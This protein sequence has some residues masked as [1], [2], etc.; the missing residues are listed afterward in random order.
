[1]P[2]KTKISKAGAKAAKLAIDN[3]TNVAEAVAE[4]VK[5]VCAPCAPTEAAIDAA[6][7]T[8]ANTD[9]TDDAVHDAVTVL[10][11]KRAAG[12]AK[13]VNVHVASTDSDRDDAFLAALAGTVN[14]SGV[15]EFYSLIG[16][17][18]HYFNDKLEP[19]SARADDAGVFNRLQSRGRIAKA[20][21]GRTATITASPSH[22]AGV[23]SQHPA[24]FSQPGK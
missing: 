4:A 10:S 24:P 11:N 8:I 22:V 12:H 2:R 17:R 9:S 5:S 7:A 19:K 18:V 6:V 1:M 16:K 15:A 13:T 23:Q 21:D 20:S 14:D 3:G